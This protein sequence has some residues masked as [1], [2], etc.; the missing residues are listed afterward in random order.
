M[1]LCIGTTPAAQRVMVFRKLALDAV[2]RAVMTWDGPAGKAVNVA[3]VL[4]ALGEQPRAAIFLGGARGEELRAGLEEL[5]VE[6]D[7]VTVEAPTRQCITVID[8]STG[9]VTELVEEGRPVAPGDF[10]RLGAIIR[11]RISGARAVIMSGTI[12]A[13]GPVDFYYQCVQRAL[14]AGAL[15]VVDAQGRALAEALKAGP[16][17]VKPNLAELAATVGRELKDEREVLCALRELS[18]R[19]A[20][21]VVVTAGKA[22]AL[23]FDG[24]SCWR[25]LPPPIRSVNPIGSGDAFTGAMVWRLVRG[26]DLGEACRW[27]S[28]AG[29]A[30]ALNPTV[31]EVTREEVERLAGMVQVERIS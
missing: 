23:A 21:R 11:Q 13:G 24:R 18:G 8:E 29:A 17:L 10:E 15:A 3:K 2:N 5:G 9:T 6:L 12:A 27:A 14:A 20:R 1:I 16:D 19:G 7:V 31:G 30:N 4:K 25:I 26:D 28:A 22:P